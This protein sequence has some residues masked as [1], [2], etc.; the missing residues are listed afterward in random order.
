MS[1]EA[2]TLTFAGLVV[3]NMDYILLFDC[4]IV[5]NNGILI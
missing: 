1:I 2:S 4:L 3:E 5:Y